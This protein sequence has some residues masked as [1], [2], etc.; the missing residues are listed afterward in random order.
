MLVNNRLIGSANLNSQ[1][2]VPANTTLL[3]SDL[4]KIHIVTANC[5]VTLPS[6][7]N[8]A[9][10]SYHI[11]IDTT[12]SQTVT[13]TAAA[14]ETIDGQQSRILWAGESLTLF[15]TGSVWKKISGKTIPIISGLLKTADQSTTSGSVTK[16]ILQTSYASNFSHAI[17][18]TNS[19]IY[20]RRTGIYSCIA[21]A[22]WKNV[23]VAGAYETLIYLNGSEVFNTSRYMQAG[24]WGAVSA[25]HN[26][27]LAAG[28]YLEAWARQYT[29]SAQTLFGGS[30]GAGIGGLFVTEQLQW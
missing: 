28:D 17:D 1:I 4:E 10:R 2:S 14:S 26:F 16:Q 13:I 5:T 27:S 20:V 22:R 30:A 3:A 19:R 15:S 24:D 18:T 6:A 29:G 21:T 12:V 11:I 9:N 25:V 23:T 7:T 8:C